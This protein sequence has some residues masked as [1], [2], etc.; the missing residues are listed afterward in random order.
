VVIERY[1]SYVQRP[2]SSSAMLVHVYRSA[3]RE[4]ELLGIIY[5]GTPVDAITLANGIVT[6][7][8]GPAGAKTTSRH[9]WQAD[10]F[11]DLP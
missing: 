6:I 4:P 2:G 11:V 9:R 5:A 3:N 1:A 8:S 10:G 7:T